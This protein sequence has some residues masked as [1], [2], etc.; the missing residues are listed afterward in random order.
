M[1]SRGDQ[2]GDACSARAFFFAARTYWLELW[3][4]LRRELR[5]WREHAESIPDADL[6]RVA[7][8]A[9]HAKRRNVEG[10][11]AF[12][13]FAQPEHRLCSA[14]A[15]AAYET[16][17]D[18]LDC[19]CEMP[20]SDPI[21]NGH[22]L[23][24]ALAVAVQPGHEHDDYYERCEHA[25]RDNRY[26]RMLIETCQQSL[27]PLPNYPL[28][29]TG[30]LRVS[31]RIATY[32]SLNH[33]DA[34]GSHHVFAEWAARKA[35]E[36]HTSGNGPSLHWWEVG[37]ASGSSLAAFALIT[38]AT[39]P[40]TTPGQVF[41]IDRAYFPW[42]GAANS[43]LDSLVNQTEDTAPGQHRLLDYYDSTEHLA[44]RLQLITGEARQ[45]AHTA[46]PSHG[47]TL[48]VAAM[49]GF[50]LT[51]PEARRPEARAVCDRLRHTA[52]S[53]R[54]DRLSTLTMRIRNLASTARSHY[55]KG[56]P[57]ST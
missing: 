25:T 41:A 20:N 53:R 36:H 52:T 44:A 5:A 24:Q 55:R 19:L 26:L 9:Q 32:Q 56:K 35:A 49:V 43:L 14:R 31:N 37:A 38:A 17:F 48:I 54:V 2:R 16:A 23:M 12:A 34:T 29:S 47:H 10:A 46:D 57:L 50:Y 6:R 39:D 40:N 27:A 51:Q 13:A 3:P 11:V 33:G 18:Y 28:V 22:K 45:R 30:L 1:P 42:I 15:M 8:T 4:I 21:T 7:L